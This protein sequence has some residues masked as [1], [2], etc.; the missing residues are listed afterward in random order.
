MFSGPVPRHRLRLLLWVAL[1]CWAAGVLWLSSL[2]PPELPGAAFLLSDKI[3]HFLA[4]AVGGWLA[5]N[6]LTVTRPNAT[7]SARLAVAV[8]IV[9]AVGV[10]DETLQRFTPGRAGGDVGDVIADLLGAIAGALL[11]LLV[12]TGSRGRREGR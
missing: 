9:T 8:L 7:V 6:A 12:R 1:L 10:L 2:S 5:A 11:G 4:Y 3:N